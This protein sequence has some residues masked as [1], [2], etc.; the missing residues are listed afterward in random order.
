MLRLEPAQ[1]PAGQQGMHPR[2]QWYGGFE[3][4]N[5]CWEFRPRLGH[6]VG[7]RGD[8]RGGLDGHTVTRRWECVPS[9]HV[10]MQGDGLGRC[11]PWEASA[12]GQQGG[13]RGRGCAQDEAEG[14]S[15]PGL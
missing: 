12:V 8:E 2:D 7:G 5:G 9:K 1:I 11:F 3:G 13:P 15:G 14:V 10:L 6:P 4:V